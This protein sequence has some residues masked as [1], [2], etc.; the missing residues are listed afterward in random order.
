LLTSPTYHTR[1]LTKIIAFAFEYSSIF[2]EQRYH[3]LQPLTSYLQPSI[4]ITLSFR[5]HKINQ[6]KNARLADAEF[7]LKDRKKDK[8]DP[9]FLEGAEGGRCFHLQNGSAMP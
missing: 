4:S 7:K 8:A 3:S 2:Y 6:I 1:R 9:F 5:E